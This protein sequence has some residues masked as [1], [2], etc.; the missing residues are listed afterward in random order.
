[1]SRSC[2]L[3]EQLPALGT[4]SSSSAVTVCWIMGAA[5]FSSN[6]ATSRVLFCH[7]AGGLVAPDY[8]NSSAEC[9]VLGFFFP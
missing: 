4:L 7:D 2:F 8:N 3:L 6:D 5:F 9:C 1:M